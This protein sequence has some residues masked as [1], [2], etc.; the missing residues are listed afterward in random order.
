MIEVLLSACGAFVFVEVLQL[1]V[2]LRLPKRKPFDCSVCLAGWFTLALFLFP[3]P[4][5]KIPF[6]MAAA[7]VAVVLITKIIALMKK[8]IGN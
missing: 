5:V 2:V 1:N 4:F 7:M 3:Y 8:L 6:Y